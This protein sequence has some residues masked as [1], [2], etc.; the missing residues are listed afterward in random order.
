MLTWLTTRWTSTRL[1]LIPNRVVRPRLAALIS[2]RSNPTKT[3]IPR[4]AGDFVILNI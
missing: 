1:T 3:I 4:L 2:P